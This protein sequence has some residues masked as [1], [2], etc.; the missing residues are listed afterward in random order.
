MVVILRLNSEWKC[1]SCGG[2]GDLLMRKIPVRYVRGL[3][4][5]EFLLAGAAPLSRRVTA[6]STTCAV[7]VSFSRSCRRCE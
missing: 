2:R 7:I 6:K 1:H 5:L 3:D 4:E